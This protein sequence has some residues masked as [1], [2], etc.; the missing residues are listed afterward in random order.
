M[1]IQLVNCAVVGCIIMIVTRGMRDFLEQR[2]LHV[3]VCIY[4][5]CIYRYK[6]VIVNKE[7]R[8]NRHTDDVWLRRTRIGEGKKNHA[9]YI[10]ATF[11][12][13]GATAALISAMMAI[14]RWVQRIIDNNIYIILFFVCIYPTRQ[15][16]C[17][18]L[19]L[20]DNG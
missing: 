9:M 6:I 10:D 20:H 3:P 5:V 14:E 19:R 15:L 1:Y 7:H 8:P 12:P 18:R 17:S 11:N 16:Y 2:A 13:D 4:G